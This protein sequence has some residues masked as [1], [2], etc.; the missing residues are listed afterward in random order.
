MRTPCLIA[1]GSMI[2]LAA[3][4]RTTASLLTPGTSL[5]AT[6]ESA[7]MVYDTPAQA[8]SGY[9]EVALIKS[10]GHGL[11]TSP[12]AM[13]RSMRSKAASVGA[14]GIIL[15]GIDG[16]GTVSAAVETALS[17]PSRREGMALAIYS[18]ADSSRTSACTTQR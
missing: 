16:P 17:I 18:P 3:C 14:T 9:K 7:I 11:L 5:P 12:A 1:L 2:S 15:T 4:A 8:P 13:R 10:E 6:C